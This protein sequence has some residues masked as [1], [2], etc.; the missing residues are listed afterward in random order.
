M[1]QNLQ[2]ILF[3]LTQSSFR[4]SCWQKEC[5]VR[6]YTFYIHVWLHIWSWRSTIERKKKN[7]PHSSFFGKHI[8]PLLR[9][10]HWKTTVANIEMFSPNF[11]TP[12][13][14]WYSKILHARTN[15]TSSQFPTRTNDFRHSKILDNKLLSSSKVGT[16]LSLLFHSSKYKPVSLL[17]QLA[18]GSYFHKAAALQNH[19]MINL[20]LTCNILVEAGEILSVPSR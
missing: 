19:R 2:T 10:K 6:F 20:Y 8:I 12:I 7:S 11:L 15:I 1:I 3:Q 13:F 14:P 16:I 9:G 5:T 18:K 4:V 17:G